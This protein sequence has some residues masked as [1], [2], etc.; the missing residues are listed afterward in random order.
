MAGQQCGPRP[1]ESA[2]RRRRATDRTRHSA[3]ASFSCGC[4]SALT[5]A[6]ASR[7]RKSPR[8][9]SQLRPE[10]D[11]PV[12]PHRR[13][14]HEIHMPPICRHQPPARAHSPRDAAA[15]HSGAPASS[16][17]APPEKPPLLKK[18]SPARLTNQRSQNQDDSCLARSMAPSDCL[19]RQEINIADRW[20]CFIAKHLFR[21]HSMSAIFLHVTNEQLDAVHSLFFTVLIIDVQATERLK[22]SSSFQ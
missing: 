4:A 21:D 8:Y 7:H 20:P 13:S 18:W 1:A 19:N 3:T 12:R 5:T 15:A 11:G 22:I 16:S 17:R 2:S 14:R 9:P 10:A 6:T